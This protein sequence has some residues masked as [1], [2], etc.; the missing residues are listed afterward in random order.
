MLVSAEMLT[1]F[2]VFLWVVY[3]SWIQFHHVPLYLEWAPVNVFKPEASQE[4][5]P[6]ADRQGEGQDEERTHELGEAIQE[7]GR[8][9]EAERR[10]S[11]STLSEL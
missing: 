5:P 4:P 10:T 6:G 7:A 3:F 1:L 8:Q 11:E 2:G 9:E